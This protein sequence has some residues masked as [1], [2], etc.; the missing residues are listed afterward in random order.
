[1]TMVDMTKRTDYKFDFPAGMDPAVVFEMHR[2]Y[3]ECMHCGFELPPE[4]CRE[5]ALDSRKGA[6]RRAILRAVDDRRGTGALRGEE[7][8]SS[9]FIAEQAAHRHFMLLDHAQTQLKGRFS[10]EEFQVILNVECQPIWE[11]DPMM[12]VAQMVADDNGICRL[13]HLEEGSPM[14]QLLEKLLALTPLE[15]AAVVDACERVWR[16][17]DN[18]LL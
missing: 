10:E 17:Y 11:C 6:R 18:P 2:H 3:D 7:R 14:R 5:Y 8:Y 9:G 13:K 1:M 16:G 12:S 15:N 4:Q